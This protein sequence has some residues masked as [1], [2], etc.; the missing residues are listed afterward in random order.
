MITE[1]YLIELNTEISSGNEK[2]KITA[3]FL[4]Y[5][6]DLEYDI[7]VYKCKYKK[8]FILPY[9][10]DK[11]YSLLRK[12][13]K[14]RTLCLCKINKDFVEEIYINIRCLENDKWN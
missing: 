6:E 8:P 7:G 14:D 3:K 2:P 5:E 10:T 1:G 9:Y 11:E 4:F 13:F 12:I